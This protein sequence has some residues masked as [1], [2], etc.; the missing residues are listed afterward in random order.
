MKGKIN[1]AIIRVFMSLKK[2]RIISE[3]V[4]IFSGPKN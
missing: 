2:K 3:I 4:S 1:D